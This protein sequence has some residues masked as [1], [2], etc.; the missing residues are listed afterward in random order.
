[1]QLAKDKLLSVL[2]SYI[3]EGKDLED[4]A[5]STIAKDAE[6]GKST[7]YEYFTSKDEMIE[8]TYRYLLKHYE[9]I[10]LSDLELMDFESAF[11]EEIRRSLFVMKDAQA[12][13]EAIMKHP[14]T[15]MMR[16]NHELKDE[17]E[18]IQDAMQKRFESIMRVGVIEGKIPTK[19]PNPH[20]RYVIQA[21]ISGLMFQF[22]HQEMNISEDE[23]IELIYQEVQKTLS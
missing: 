23:L 5:L 9:D 2:V 4:I 17:M 3:K 1:M 20:K 22:V 8:E 7:V 21:L 6:I 14:S 19:V 15:K 16:L 12:L 10:L 13:M 11:K 18:H